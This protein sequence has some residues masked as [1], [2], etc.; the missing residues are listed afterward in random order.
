MPRDVEKLFR[1]PIAK[2]FPASGALAIRRYAHTEIRTTPSSLPRRPPPMATNGSRSAYSLTRQAA[3]HCQSAA[4]SRVVS[5]IQC[6]SR[7]F[8]TT[9]SRKEAEA[10]SKLDQMSRKTAEAE[11]PDEIRQRPRWSYTP[12][13]MKAP[14]SPHITKNPARSVWKVNEDPKKLDQMYVKLLGRDGDKMLPDETK[15]LAVT[16]K[17]FDQGRRGF[18][19]KLAYLGRQAVILETTNRIVTG[20]D[21]L[22][23]AIVPEKSYQRTPFEH[24]A[25]TR[26]DNLNAEQPQKIVTKEKVEALALAAGLDKVLRWKPAKPEN[27]SGSGQQIVLNSAV[28][29]IVGAIT[30]QHGAEVAGRVIRD[31]IL[32]PLSANR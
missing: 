12:E 5:P 26:V 32:R 4:N 8:A 20:T 1:A 11:R 18:N 23:K 10:E 9:S 15:W 27:L 2:K 17:S 25:L 3:R 14:F 13:G 29:A 21:P 30:L 19:D 7:S 22:K 6:L 28:F 24:P 16:H 31:R